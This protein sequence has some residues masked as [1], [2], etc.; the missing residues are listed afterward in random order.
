MHIQ[1]LT[2][3]QVVASIHSSPGLLTTCPQIASTL[4]LGILSG[5]GLGTAAMRAANA[6]RSQ[7][8]LLHAYQQVQQGLVFANRP[9]CV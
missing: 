5:W 2:G 1:S 6:A 9:A 3:S 7:E 4:I 8:A